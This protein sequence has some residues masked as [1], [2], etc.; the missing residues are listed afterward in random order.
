MTDPH[1]SPAGDAVTRPT[2]LRPATNVGIHE[3]LAG[4]WSPRAID[5]D[6]SV[7]GDV[8]V[9]L[10]EAARWAPSSA[11]EQPWRFLVFD[12]RCPRARE[13]ARSCLNDGNSWA[14]A[15]PVLVVTVAQEVWIHRGNP[16]GQPHPGARYDLGAAT[17]ALVLQ[18]AAEGLVAHQMGGFDKDAAREQLGVPD[19]FAPVTMVAIGHPGR[20][21]DLSEHNQNREVQPRQR[22]PLGDIAFHG[23]WGHPLDG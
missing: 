12:D 18:A 3:L 14:K 22:R 1:A 17:M 16:P 19:D 5:P 4:R 6:T 9:R 21:T 7:A 11:N 13:Q 8:V 20:I 10:L 2:I 23:S 15:A